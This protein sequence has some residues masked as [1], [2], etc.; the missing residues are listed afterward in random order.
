M[1]HETIYRSAY[2]QARGA[3]K[4]TLPE[5]LHRTRTM[6]RSRHHTQ[7]TDNY[8]R[9]V[10]AV[11]IRERPVT[12]ADRAAPGHWQGDLLCGS[13]NSQIVTLVEGQARYVRLIKVAA[14]I[15]KQ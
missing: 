5:H 7:N 12:A 4:K 13:Y 6:R 10:D 9:I 1:P 8:G 14:Q 11:S 15:P 3:L 2:I